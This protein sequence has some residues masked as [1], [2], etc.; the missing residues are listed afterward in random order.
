[1]LRY[2]T[3]RW[4]LMLLFCFSSS[5]HLQPQFAD[6]KALWNEISIKVESSTHHPKPSP[7][8]VL[9]SS[10][11]SNEVKEASISSQ[12][13]F[14]YQAEL[15]HLYEVGEIT[16][17]ELEKSLQLEQYADFKLNLT[18]EQPRP[19]PRAL[20]EVKRV[21][22]DHELIKLELQ[23]DVLKFFS[24]LLFSPHIKPELYQNRLDLSAVNHVP[25]YIKIVLVHIRLINQSYH[26]P[27]FNAE[28]L[29]ATQKSAFAT[30]K[31]FFIEVFLG[32]GSNQKRKGI[33]C[34]SRKQIKWSEEVKRIRNE[35]VRPRRDPLQI[36]ASTWYITKLWMKIK[37]N[38]LYQHFKRNR[39]QRFATL[40]GFINDK[41]WFEKENPTI[42]ETLDTFKL[43]VPQQFLKEKNAER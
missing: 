18:P 6:A 25:D 30:L 43:R 38:P 15:P 27:L 1:M 39:G 8:L 13:N 10:E 19:I 16:K 11:R 34:S 9:E 17:E 26:P 31:F 22:G 40:K 14:V 28:T 35:F 7:H 5:S 29:P 24:H 42:A 37:L 21:L 2:F 3:L 23:D 41:A 32:Q 33:T 12:F 4:S 20:F 36:L